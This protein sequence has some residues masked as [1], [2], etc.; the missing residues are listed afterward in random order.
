MQLKRP[1]HPDIYDTISQW[2]DNRHGVPYI[3]HAITRNGNAVAL[4]GGPVL[5][6]GNQ[7]FASNH[8]D[9]RFW[10]TQGTAIWNTLQPIMNNIVCIEID[11]AL[12]P[13]T[14]QGGCAFRVPGLIRRINPLLAS[15]PLRIYSHRDEH[16]NPAGTSTKRYYDANTADGDAIA[17]QRYNAHQDWS[18][19][20]WVG[21]PSYAALYS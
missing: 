13:C 16:M 10:T 20:D 7:N 18:W 8:P 2:F 14:G 21:K 19:S 4:A 6:E 1:K 15:V 11:C 5:G 9:Q 17:L 3:A 12:M